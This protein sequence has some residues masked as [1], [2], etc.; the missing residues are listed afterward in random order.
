[1]KILTLINVLVCTALS[2]MPALALDLGNSIPE[3][4][5]LSL[6]A[7]GIGAAAWVKYRGRNKK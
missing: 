1:M 7:I 5:A 4:S 6:L 2:S 3:P